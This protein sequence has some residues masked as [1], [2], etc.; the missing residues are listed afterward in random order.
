MGLLGGVEPT[1]LP[2]FSDEDVPLAL[3]WFLSRAILLLRSQHRLE[4]V[5]VDPGACSGSLCI[6]YSGECRERSAGNRSE[7]DFV[8]RVSSR[9]EG[10]CVESGGRRGGDLSA[11]PTLPT[12]WL[13]MRRRP[14]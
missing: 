12:A 6:C 14:T 4:A 8:H 3:V 10:D 2:A 5:P 13:L 11:T 7:I 9:H 1:V